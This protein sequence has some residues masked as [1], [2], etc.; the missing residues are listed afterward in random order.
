LIPEVTFAHDCII[1]DA[2]CIISLYASGQMAEVLKAIPK[3]ITVAAYVSN[4]EALWS[5]SGPDWDIRSDKE[6][7]DL[8]P[9]VEA[10]L[11][12]IVDIDNEAEKELFVDLVVGL[13][14]G[15]AIT[16]AI[17]IHRNWAISIDDKKARTLFEREAPHLQ[18]IYMLELVKYWVDVAYPSPTTIASALRNIQTRAVYRPGP[19]HSLYAW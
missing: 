2:S 19:S 11:L 14:P 6:R 18:L 9:F 10:G 5:Y 13:G 16:G 4:K 8:Q 1:L 3:T 7:I 17:A 15:E 12:K